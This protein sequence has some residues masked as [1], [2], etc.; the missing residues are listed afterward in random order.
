MLLLFGVGGD[1]DGSQHR[2]GRTRLALDRQAALGV[3]THLVQ[4]RLVGTL[5]ALAEGACFGAGIDSR[6][7]RSGSPHPFPP[8]P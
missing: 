4:G 6:I 1:V 7:A 8:H 5:D 2:L 3:R